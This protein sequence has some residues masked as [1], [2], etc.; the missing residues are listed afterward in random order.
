MAEN[1]LT[2]GSGIRTDFYNV[3]QVQPSPAVSN[4]LMG[5]MQA[6]QAASQGI[7]LQQQQM[8]LGL[9]RLNY[10]QNQFGALMAKPDVSF[11]DVANVAANMVRNNIAPAGE[12]ASQLAN[13]PRDSAGIKAWALQHQMNV[14]DHA[15]R[16]QGTF[17]MPHQIDNGNT[18]IPGAVSPYTGGFTPAG[19]AVPR[20]TSPSERLTPDVVTDTQG[21]PVQTTRAQSA[22]GKG[23]DPVR[24]MP[25]SRAA[26]VAG[27]PGAPPGYTEAAT[28]A[29][30]S[31]AEQGANVQRAAEGS[32]E[33]RGALA[34]LED[35][36]SKFT[37]GPLASH[38][39]AIKRGLNEVATRAG[40]P[41]PFDANSIAKQ[42]GFNKQAVQLA[43]KQF[44]ALGGT[45]T[46]S[47]LSSA[48][49]S[50]PNE[51]L[52]TMGNRQIIALLKGN[53]DAIE[54]RAS[55]WN[56]WQ[57]KNGA[58]SYGDFQQDWNKNYS[59]RAFQWVRMTPAERE[60]A[61]ANMSPAEKKSLKGA[62]DNAADRGWI[63][64]P[65]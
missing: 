59:P 1:M 46:D 44:A 56:A 64:E 10:M 21:N 19:G 32:P 12:I 27:I 35:D 50:N 40:A 53:E 52:S 14:A 31:S 6:Q 26:P 37:T 17:G 23:M 39:L 20:E 43:Q 47:Q 2:G 9:Q 42:E 5:F 63:S 51:A 16:M 62:L 3:P 54:T 60:E 61:K 15:Q 36:L 11:D 58:N 30:R 22:A 4:P 41:L 13:V 57:K 25:M 45:G 28:V 24:G 33:R 55:A 18:I 7:G 29:A 65:K 34:T 49:K 38:A 8:A 48:F